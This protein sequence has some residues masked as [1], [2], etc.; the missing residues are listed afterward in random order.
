[1]RRRL[2]LAALAVLAPALSACG[3]DDPT[4]PGI[5]PELV[6]GI[7]TPT[8]LGFDPQGSLQEV[9]LLDGIGQEI[10]PFLS[11]AT[12]RSFQFLFIDNQTKEVVVA[13]GTYETLTGGIRLTFKNA[14]DARRLLLPTTLDLSF[15]ELAGT[16]SFT[17]DV[18]APRARLFELV[19]EWANE[20]LA[21]PVPG[22]LTVEF[23]VL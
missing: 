7:Y 3:G 17:G 16:L 4:E 13:S 2:I 11:V 23:T 9:N 18:S 5:D 14:T 21:D 8:V 12:N 1:M 10:V 22:T 20:P 15:D 6:A 19:P